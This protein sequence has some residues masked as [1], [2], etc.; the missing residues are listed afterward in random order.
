MSR[1]WLLVCNRDGGARRG[2]GTARRG[3]I[4]PGSEGAALERRIVSVNEELIQL[5]DETVVRVRQGV[6]W[7]SRPTSDN[8]TS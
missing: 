2:H 1:A 6:E 8:G 7:L 4:G 5:F 3:T